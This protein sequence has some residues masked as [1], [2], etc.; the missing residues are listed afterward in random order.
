MNHKQKLIKTVISGDN[1][2][3]LWIS[4]NKNNDLLILTPCLLIGFLPEL[5]L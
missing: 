4:D 1:I 5:L 2:T 3:G